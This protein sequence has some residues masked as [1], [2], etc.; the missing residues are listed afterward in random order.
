MIGGTWVQEHEAR[1]T[2]AGLLEVRRQIRTNLGRLNVV[3]RGRDWHFFERSVTKHTQ[4]SSD[5]ANA[6]GIGLRRS[7]ST[8]NVKVVCS[9]LQRLLFVC[10]FLVLPGQSR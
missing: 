1:G 2:V 3:L 4:T 6:I 9:S 7:E 5:T 10:L 8:D